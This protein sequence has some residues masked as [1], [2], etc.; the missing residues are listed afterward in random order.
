MAVPMCGA[1][2]FIPRVPVTDAHTAATPTHASP[3]TDP[4]GAQAF[5]AHKGREK[6]TPEQFPIVAET[7]SNRCRPISSNAS[8][9]RHVHNLAFLCEHVAPPRGCMWAYDAAGTRKRQC[10][11]KLPFTLTAYFCAIDLQECIHQWRAGHRCLGNGTLEVCCAT[12]LRRKPWVDGHFCP[13]TRPS[14]RQPARPTTR[15]RSVRE[16]GNR[17]ATRLRPHPKE[18]GGGRAAGWAPSSV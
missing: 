17:F 10:A 6:K 8:P 13:V 14:R 2:P 7:P 16:V 1:P 4:R 5:K 3:P 18:G 15:A 11:R 12:T 9:S